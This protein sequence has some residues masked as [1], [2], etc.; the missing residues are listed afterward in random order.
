MVMS[1]TFNLK[2]KKIWGEN[3]TIFKKK[4]E[5]SIGNNWSNDWSHKTNI[6]SILLFSEKRCRG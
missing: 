5:K 4:K 6:L 2:Q 1:A 3:I